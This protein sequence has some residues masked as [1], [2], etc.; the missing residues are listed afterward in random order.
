MS[1]RP[2]WDGYRPQE[3]TARL[4]TAY[5]CGDLQLFRSRSDSRGRCGRYFTGLYLWAPD[6]ST[7]IL[8]L[9]ER[10]ADAPSA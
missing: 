2:P 4:S 1:Y 6:R 3:S 10:D 5:E 7:C 9:P 8:L